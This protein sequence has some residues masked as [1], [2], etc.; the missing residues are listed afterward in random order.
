MTSMLQLRVIPDRSVALSRPASAHRPLVRALG[1]AAASLLLA[2]AGLIAPLSVS[3][4]LATVHDVVMGDSTV[5]LD[6]S[7]GVWSI[8]DEPVDGC[9]TFPDGVST[10]PGNTDLAD[11]TVCE[12]APNSWSW[13]V[14]IPGPSTI[15]YTF[16]NFPP[17]YTVCGQ[18][19]FPRDGG[20]FQVSVDLVLNWMAIRNNETNRLVYNG[21]IEDFSPGSYGFRDGGATRC[22]KYHME[23]PSPTERVSWGQIK[24][25]Y[26]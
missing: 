3:A 2:C 15:S 22:G 12:P 24:K 25:A 6:W 9:V 1:T 4:Q 26:R 7:E 21:S 14:T 20:D 18:L 17:D 11:S 23:E 19:F 5:V 16:N 13:S 8:G 10:G